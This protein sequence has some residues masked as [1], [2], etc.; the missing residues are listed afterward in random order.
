MSASVLDLSCELVAQLDELVNTRG[1]YA[2]GR[3][4]GLCAYCYAH[5]RLD[6]LRSKRVGYSAIVISP[7]ELK[8]GPVNRQ[9]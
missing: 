9:I 1:S 8:F 5:A 6:V 2:S 7:Y 3:F 4:R